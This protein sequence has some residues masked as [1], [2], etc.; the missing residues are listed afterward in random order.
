MKTGVTNT[1]SQFIYK[2]SERGNKDP[3]FLLLKKYIGIFKP[4]LIRSLLSER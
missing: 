3:K 4:P 2:Y 1:V